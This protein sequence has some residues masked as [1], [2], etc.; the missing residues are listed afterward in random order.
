MVSAESQQII[1]TS[2]DKLDDKKTTAVLA[3]NDPTLIYWLSSRYDKVFVFDI[4]QQQTHHY[5]N[6][7]YVNLALDKKTT[8][9]SYCPIQ[10]KTVGWDRDMDANIHAVTLDQLKLPKVSL[11]VYKMNGFDRFAIKGSL[12]TIILEKPL[13]VLD[14]VTGIAGQFVIDR[15]NYI[16]H[17]K[18]KQLKVMRC[19]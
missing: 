14:D 3:Y 19:R 15:C 6:V 18:T 5:N 10:N 8:Q 11:I 12:K 2:I 16:E 9:V 17:C 13:V 1:L 4:T 7:F